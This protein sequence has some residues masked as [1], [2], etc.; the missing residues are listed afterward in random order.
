MDSITNAISEAME[1]MTQSG[2][3]NPADYE[4]DGILYCGDCGEPKQAWI[5]WIPDAD[6]NSAKRLV[7]VV[8]RCE[9]E[10]DEREN[11]RIIEQVF[12][13]R[14]RDFTFFIHG[15]KPVISKQRFSDDENPKS[16]IARTCRKYVA[17]WEKMQKHNLG[18]LFYGDRGTGKSFYA[19]AI[20]NALVEQKV[21]AVMTT[22]ANIMAVLSSWDKEEALRYIANVPLLA[23]DDL[24]AERDTTYSAELMYSVIDTRCRA[25]KPTIITTNLDLED[26]KNELDPWRS[27]IYDRVLEMCPIA[28]PMTGTSRRRDIFEERRTM[29]RDFLKSGKE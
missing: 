11:A 21:I 20:V 29:A 14:L 3:R 27:R 7:P 6:G 15:A 26:M 9:R 24:G 18:I 28:I 23:L 25:A 5:D 19:S 10:A 8:C 22:T 13:D 4:K 12:Q 2:N 17:E 1:H 16:S